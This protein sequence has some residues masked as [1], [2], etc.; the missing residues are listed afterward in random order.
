MAPD[1]YRIDL[2]SVNDFTSGPTLK[3]LRQLMGVCEVVGKSKHH[4]LDKNSWDK[5]KRQQKKTDSIVM[6]NVWI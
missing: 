6:L 4:N 5:T 3:G 1:E 2:V